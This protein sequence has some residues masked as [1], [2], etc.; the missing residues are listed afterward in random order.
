MSQVHKKSFGQHFLHDKGVI[1]SIVK[2]LGEI[3]EEL[4]VEIGPGSGALTYE[5]IDL[6]PRG[7]L[8]LIEADRDLVP[9]LQ[10]K[11]SATIIRADA[12][13]VDYAPI[14]NDSDWVMI[15]NLPYNA[16]SA[17]LM[18]AL[19]YSVPPLR[20]IIMV[21][22]EQADRMLAKPGDMG[23]LSVAVQ[24]YTR[25]RRCFNVGRGAFNPP[26]NVESTVLEL[27]T[28]PDVDTLLNEQI[29]VLA[30]AGFAARRKQLAGNIEA[31]QI[32]TKQVV[33]NTL[34]Q[35]GVSAKARAQE[36]SVDQW[37][38]LYLALQEKH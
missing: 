34:E 27:T 20:S 38:Q 32:A 8:V 30:R 18:H 9:N 15:G 29:L 25:P 23:L 17:I 10:E 3:D 14:V 12:A 16:A 31:A 22:K 28:L 36:L 4:V 6:V 13:R 24:L 1:H 5:L 37:Q 19:S 7:Q 11:Y 35:I 26:P 33:Q 2:V 21:Q